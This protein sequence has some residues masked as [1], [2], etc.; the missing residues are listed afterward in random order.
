MQTDEPN[1]P[2]PPTA[3]P[4]RRRLLHLTA[5]AAAI[6]FPALW[7]GA[8]AQPVAPRRPTPSQTEGPFYPVEIPPD[9]DAD[10][11]RNGA[12][13]TQRGEPA[14]VQGTVSDMAGLPVSG[15][16]VE[17]WQC[18]ADGH[19]HHP[20]DRGTPDPAFQGFGRMTVGADGAY[21]FRTLRPAVYSGRTPHIHF[22]VRLD[23]RE[24]LTTQLY[25]EGDPNN[26]R[27]G[28]WRRIGDPQD[29]AAITVP[30]SPGVDGL[31]ARFPIVVAA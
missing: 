10:L 28:L 2:K 20:R 1:M 5:G 22:K 26:E 7:L 16:V 8:R 23:S 12:L 6:S 25:V 31:Q 18:D 24:L 29:R 13:R 3:L 9:H 4:T 15:A 14:W 30:F 17:I 11:L 27:D 19:Y 21:R